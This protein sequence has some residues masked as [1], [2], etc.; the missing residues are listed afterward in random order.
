MFY[1][2]FNLYYFFRWFIFQILLSKC[3][4]LV[5]LPLNPAIICLF[6]Y[7]HTWIFNPHFD[8][9]IDQPQHLGFIVHIHHITHYGSY[10]GVV[11]RFDGDDVRITQAGLGDEDLVLDFVDQDQ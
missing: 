11:C 9:M 10:V 2:G 7:D 3:M 1:F 8:Q 4:S 5:D 6:A